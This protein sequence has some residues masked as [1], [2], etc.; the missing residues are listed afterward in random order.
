MVS[1]TVGSYIQ[2]LGGQPKAMAVACIVLGFLGPPDQ[3]LEGRSP[4][5]GTGVV[6]NL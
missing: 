1:S 6:V 5:P 3:Q 2:V 4:L